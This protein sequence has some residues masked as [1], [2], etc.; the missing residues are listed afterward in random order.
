MGILDDLREQAEK[1]I[2]E[3]SADKMSEENKQHVYTTLIAPKMK[4]IYLY[5]KEFSQ[6]LNIIKNPVKVP[7]YSK[8][9]PD[10]GE[11]SQTEF[12]THNDNYGGLVNNDKIH[13]VVLRFRYKEPNTREYVHYTDSKLEADQIQNFLYSHNLPVASSRNLASKNNGALIFYITK[14]I[15]VLFKFVSNPEQANIILNI[16]HHENFEERSLSINPHDINEAFLDKLARYILREDSDFLNI[17]IDDSFRD[18]IQQKIE[19][20]REKEWQEEQQEEPQEKQEKSFMGKL[21]K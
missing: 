11:L 5:F 6:H 1:K 7:N 14:D 3:Q 12:K 19:A 10:M 2:N 16:R 15:P 4:Q 13:E 9:F 20:E 21:F 18:K 8:L 17:D